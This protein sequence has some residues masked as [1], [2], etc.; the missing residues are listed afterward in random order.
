MRSQISRGINLGSPD[1]V[2][3]SSCFSSLF[4]SLFFAFASPSQLQM[5][6]TLTRSPLRQAHS[7]FHPVIS[8][9]EVIFQLVPDV[10]CQLVLA[11]LGKEEEEPARKEEDEDVSEE[12]DCPCEKEDCPCEK[13][14]CPCK[15][16]DCPC[17]KE[18]CPCKKEEDE[19]AVIL[20][21]RKSRSLCEGVV[22]HET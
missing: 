11:A 22:G 15:K 6:S 14:D 9:P 4:Q 16:E 1:P 5:P 3:P 18:D 2:P 20:P 21:L 17:E 19:K 13:E 10:V 7:S 12:E 8:P